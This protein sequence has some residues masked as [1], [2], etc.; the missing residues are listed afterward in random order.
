MRYS[1]PPI[2]QGLFFGAGD[3][4][5]NPHDQLGSSVLRVSDDMHTWPKKDPLVT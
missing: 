2:C 4:N 5:R 3:G 1:F